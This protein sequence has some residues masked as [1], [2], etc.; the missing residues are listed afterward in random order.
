M[1]VGSKGPIQVSPLISNPMCPGSITCPAGKVVPRITY[2]TCSAM[3]SSL[4]APFCTEHTALL[5]S[6]QRAAALIACAVWIA[7]VATIP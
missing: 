1:F 7:F 2:F 5:W 4:P 3:I 6:K